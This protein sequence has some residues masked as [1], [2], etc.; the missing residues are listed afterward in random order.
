M[1]LLNKLTIKNLKLNKKRT[2]V[3]IIGII[4]SVALVT[5]VSSM[6]SSAIASLI[7]Y[8]T[9]VKGNNHVA[10]YHQNINTLN[11][12]KNN[13]EVEDIY[14]T[15]DYGYTYLENSK[16]EYKPYAIIKAFN[17]KALENLSINLVEGRM[18]TNSN[19][20][21]IPTHLKTNGRI[22]YTIGDEVTLNVGD[23]VNIKKEK[24]DQF[25]SLEDEEQIINTHKQTYKIVGIINRPSNSIEPYSAPGY[26]FITYNEE[27]AGN[28]FDIFVRFT[29]KGTKRH[30][31]IE[32]AILNL[33][34]H[35]YQKYMEGM[36]QAEDL[37]NNSDILSLKVMENQYLINLETN[38]FK[39]SSVGSLGV[40]VVIVSL[41]IVF[42]SIFCIKNSFD[43]S[44]TEKI[45]QYGMLRSI[46]ATKK[47]IKKNVFYEATILGLIAIPLGIVFGLLA[48][49]ILI[50]I[51]N[52][53]L[54]DGFS[55]SMKLIF[56][57][58]FYAILIAIGLGI[59][60][61]YFSAF[62]SAS[63][64]S[65]SLP[66]ELIR[67][68]ANIKLNKKKIKGNRLIKKI[69]GVGGDISYKNIK[70]N[71]RK[72]RTT[73][74]S[75]ATSV[76]VFIALTSFMSLA[77]K[78][79]KNELALQE[80][81]LLL[82]IYSKDKELV[83][84]KIEETFNIDG[85]NNYTVLEQQDFLINNPQINPQK[86]FN[87]YHEENG[88]RVY[89]L[90]VI[91]IGEKQYQKYL[92]SLNLD[93]DYMID[94]GILFDNTIVSKYDEKKKKSIDYQMREFT[95]NKN[96][97]I[98]LRKEDATIDIE[99]GLVTDKLPFGLANNLYNNYFIVSPTLYN[100]YAHSLAVN[101]FYDAKDA[102]KVQ[103]EIEQ[104][105][106]DMEYSLT[107]SE[108]N[109][110]VMNNLFTLI[111]IFLYG[112][113]IVISLIGITNIFNTITTNMELRRQEFAM[114]KS[115]GMTS[116][117]FRRMIRLESIFLGLKSLI[118][119]IPI[120]LILSY[121]I[122]YALTDSYYYSY[123]PPINAI[124]IAIIVVYLLIMI[125]MKYSLSKIN[126]Q[127]TID[128]IRNE[129]I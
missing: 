96:D 88:E 25:E 12:I 81:N 84:N 63:K 26:T 47:Q 45:K 104:I 7:K 33:D 116:K 98:S 83:N 110:R 123:T 79:T 122:Y 31:E 70:R 56:N 91:N 65:K 124:I 38:P 115:V 60:T 118:I 64:A 78:T 99:V 86:E 113:I 28:D 97:L 37:E 3:T 55:Q 42:T 105:F 53:F 48:S 2:I 1:N 117:E 27:I 21:L 51:S 54:K 67:N 77:F 50:I 89:Y 101:V 94:K 35:I 100:K 22:N 95:Y 62:R 9:T 121:L 57:F 82:H 109:A 126:K 111:G 129:N 58:S 46:G 92:D 112:F 71:K 102:T 49:Y 61:I 106:T 43:I 4:L 14:L 30:Y 108:E 18:P 114:L 10:F 32:A 87:G 34:S 59:I 15:Y 23:R 125:I 6:Y 76:I 29:K 5:A 85:I 80:Y 8:E 128:T 19:E 40:V 24:L 90:N 74:I 44:I 73:T 127:N 52:I 103:D 72:Y 39:D 13:R 41:I 107:N 69:F 66:I 93:Y 119:G 11:T 120:G 17:K 75:I 16:N 20:I 68:S 36:L